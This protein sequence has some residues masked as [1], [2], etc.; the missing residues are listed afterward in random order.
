MAGKSSGEGRGAFFR[1][2]ALLLLGVGG[3]GI[4]GA[5]P[6]WVLGELGW[7]VAVAAGIGAAVAVM[8][9]LA[10]G[11]AGMVIYAAGNAVMG[12]AWFE[13]GM[14]Q[15]AVAA[16]APCIMFGLMIRMFYQHD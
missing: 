13:G 4:G 2:V 6:G 8:G 10:N 16:A 14:P 3:L 9:I 11:M 7:P 15:W 12:A 5:L 1:A